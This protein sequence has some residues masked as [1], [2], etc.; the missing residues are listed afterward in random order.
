LHGG[1]ACLRRGP[2][3]L[4]LAA[5]DVCLRPCDQQRAASAPG[6]RG[7]GLAGI[8]F[9]SGPGLDAPQLPLQRIRQKPKASHR[10]GRI[11]RGGCCALN[12]GRSA[13]SAADAEEVPAPAH[14][15]SPASTT[16]PEAHERTA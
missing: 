4:R 15:T 12:S 8:A 10:R 6:P 3:W 2:C 1:P 14:N 9:A 16:T 5:A 11:G 13:D 7:R